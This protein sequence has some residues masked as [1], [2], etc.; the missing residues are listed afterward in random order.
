V[1]DFTPTEFGLGSAV[2]AAGSA[3]AASTVGPALVTRFGFQP[4]AAGGLVLMGLSSLLLTQVSVGGSYLEDMFIALLIFGPGIGSAHLAGTVATLTSVDEADSGLAS[5]LSNAS[6]QIGAALGVAILTTVSVSEAD[7]TNPLAALTEGFQ[8]A[9]A[10]A[11]AFAALGI[12]V[13]GLLLGRSRS[14]LAQ[15]AAVQEG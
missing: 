6:F 14:P 15:P 12:L 8:A 5:G 2:M 9:F 10:A 4:I 13:A 1:L 3:L 7:G 11:I